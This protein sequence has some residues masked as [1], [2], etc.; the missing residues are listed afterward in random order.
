MLCYRTFQGEGQLQI[1]PSKA[2]LVR[3]PKKTLSIRSFAQDAVIH[4]VV[5]RQFFVVWISTVEGF[6]NTNIVIRSFA[7]KNDPGT[8]P[9]L[10][11]LCLTFH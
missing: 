1:L 7:T 4:R 5:V 9:L 2:I 6:H 3:E 8:P 11:K 10:G